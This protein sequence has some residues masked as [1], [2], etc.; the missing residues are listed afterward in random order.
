MAD[1]EIVQLK[2]FPLQ[3]FVMD[4]V[5]QLII[6]IKTFLN[7]LV[8]YGQK[9]ASKGNHVHGRLFDPK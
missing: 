3:I 6:S 7:G 5:I 9:Q 8:N 2:I 4:I 1:D